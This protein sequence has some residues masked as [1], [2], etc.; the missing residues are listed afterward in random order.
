M[1]KIILAKIL[2]SFSFFTTKTKLEF[3]LDYHSFL[4]CNYSTQLIKLMDPLYPLPHIENHFPSLPI[5]LTKLSKWGKTILL[6]RIFYRKPQ[7]APQFPPVYIYHSVWT[8]Y[9][10]IERS[11]SNGQCPVQIPTIIFRSVLTRIF[12]SFT[13]KL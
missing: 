1:L 11:L 3:F 13:I 6:Y 8:F 5:L 7:N 2:N 12:A 10:I 9:P 4:Y